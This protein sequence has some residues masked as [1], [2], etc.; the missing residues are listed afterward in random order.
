[1]LLNVHVS[2]P[3]VDLE[4]LT[5]LSKGVVFHQLIP[6]TETQRQCYIHHFLK[7]A[8]HFVWDYIII[9]IVNKLHISLV[10]TALLP[11][12]R[13]WWYPTGHLTFIPIHAAGPRNKSIDVSQLVISSYVTTL[14]SLFQAQKKHVSII[15]EQQK[16]LCVSQPETPGQSCLPQTTKEVDKV[17]NICCSFGWPRYR[18]LCLCGSDATVNAVSDALDSCSWLH[19]AG[20]GFQDSK[21]GMKSAFA[22]HDG[23]LDLA[24]IA[25]K[26]VIKWSI[27]FSICLSSSIWT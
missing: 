1:M 19:L 9:H 2:L 3:D 18:I 22:L 23:H 16:F 27:C 7:P 8:L 11:Q 4:E 12:Q 21:L 13:I 5:E 17:V 24:E 15:K 10:D 14:Q 6:V 25:S 20:H 26:N